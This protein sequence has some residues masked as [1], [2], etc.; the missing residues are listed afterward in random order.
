MHPPLVFFGSSPFSTLVL[1]KLLTSL[2]AGRLQAVVTTPDA[3]V[4]RHL[5]L[6]PN[7]VK[8][9]AQK[10]SVP[11]FTDIKKFLNHPVPA[12]SIGLIAAYGKIIG[13]KTLGKFNNHIYGIHPSLLPKYRGPSPLQQQILDGADTGVTVL[14]IDLGEDTGPIVVQQKEAIRP[15][16]TWVTLGNRLFGLGTDL[17]IDVFLRANSAQAGRRQRPGSPSTALP[18]N[19]KL[20]TFTHKLT[21]QDGFLP[22]AEFIKFDYDRKFRAYYNWPGIWSINPEGKRV[23]LVSINPPV[24]QYADH[25]PE[26]FQP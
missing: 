10:N 21:R 3:P 13:P 15:N 7:P 9:L 19:H 18:Q 23:K 16:D 17:F 20:A 12:N 4:G 2:P 8:V 22:W 5:K 14:Q 25:K 26:V 6:T 11:V 1:D 24:I